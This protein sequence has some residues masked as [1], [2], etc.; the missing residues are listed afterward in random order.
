MEIE[1]QCEEAE[2]QTQQDT[3][4]WKGGREREREGERGR[5]MVTEEA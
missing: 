2:E 4:H 3:S 1:M 5:D